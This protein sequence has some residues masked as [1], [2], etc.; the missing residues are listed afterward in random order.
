[1]CLTVSSVAPPHQTC[2]APQPIR[3]DPITIQVCTLGDN[4]NDMLCHQSVPRSAVGSYYL[5]FFTVFRAKRRK[6]SAISGF[7]MLPAATF[8]ISV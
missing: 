8:I 7:C 3:D 1:M 5:P 4:C 2:E 6:V